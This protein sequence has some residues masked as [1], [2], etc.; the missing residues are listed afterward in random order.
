L[1]PVRSR[2]QGGLWKSTDGGDSWKDI[3]ADQKLAWPT[4][5]ALNP[6]DENT[7][8]LTAATI[9]GSAQGGGYKTTDGG[10]TVEAHHDR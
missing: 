2:S 1:G 5:F 8:Y 10:K 6:E 9:P 7:I 4:D 3:T